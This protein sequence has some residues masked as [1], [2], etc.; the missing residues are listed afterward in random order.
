MTVPLLYAV[1]VV[2]GAYTPMAC[3]SGENGCAGCSFEDLVDP[4]V[5]EGGG[6]KVG[7]GADGVGDFLALKNQPRSTPAHG[8]KHHYGTS[9]YSQ[10]PCL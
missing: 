9:R 6:F 2:C 1:S 10:Y 7:F 5:V 4:L 8:E 3:V